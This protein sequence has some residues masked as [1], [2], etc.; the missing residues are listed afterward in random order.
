MDLPNLCYH[1]NVYYADSRALPAAFFY[2][3]LTPKQARTDNGNQLNMVVAKT[4]H[5]NKITRKD[6][7]R[8]PRN[9]RRARSR[10]PDAMNQSKKTRNKP[11]SQPLMK[12]MNGPDPPCAEQTVLPARDGSVALRQHQLALLLLHH[13]QP[14]R[15]CEIRCIVPCVPTKCA[16]QKYGWI[17]Q[18]SWHT[19]Q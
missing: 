6:S 3:H 5:G 17:Q 15:H 8:N 16:T 10:A 19:P 4:E 11:T 9:P 14:H 2:F 1:S 12:H 13:H 7:K 18:N